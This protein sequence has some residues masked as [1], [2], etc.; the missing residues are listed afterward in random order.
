[1]GCGRQENAA[2]APS[3]GD[4]RSQPISRREAGAEEHHCHDAK[5]LTTAFFVPCS[6]T[7][8]LSA[9]FQISS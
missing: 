2:G 5:H 1:M 8:R 9:S 3:T 7:P 4:A 6:T